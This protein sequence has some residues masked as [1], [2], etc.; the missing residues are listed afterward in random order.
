MVSLNR[1]AQGRTSGVE[2]SGG[3]I[4][5]NQPPP[6]DNL[7]RQQ[8]AR[9]NAVGCGRRDAFRP[10]DIFERLVTNFVISGADLDQCDNSV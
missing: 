4:L 5:V 3:P 9:R 6:R 1:A 2:A 8:E 7:R 10:R